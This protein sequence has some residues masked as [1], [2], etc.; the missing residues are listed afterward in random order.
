MS[1][2][3][4]NAASDLLAK[5]VV[6]LRK[7]A[8]MNQRELAAALDREHSYIGRI[9]TGQRRIDL[10]EWVQILR[11]LNVDPEQEISRMIR[12]LLPVVAKP[13]KRHGKV[14]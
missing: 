3:M 4:H 14:D 10:I 12:K 8:G 2:S 9:E 1:S 5:A 6:E 11:V 7:K 13:R